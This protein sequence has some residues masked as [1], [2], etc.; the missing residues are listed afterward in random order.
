MSVILEV[1]LRSKQDLQGMSADGVAGFKRHLAERP[2]DKI[3]ASTLSL[4]FKFAVEEGTEDP[5][6]LLGPILG[7]DDELFGDAEDGHE[8]QEGQE[9]QEGQE[10][11]QKETLSSQGDKGEL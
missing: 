4:A 7:Q 10:Q 3:V 11:S 5:R 6:S 9:G 1:V 8:E 2:R